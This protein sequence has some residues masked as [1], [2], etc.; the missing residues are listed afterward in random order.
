MIEKKTIVDQIEVTQGGHVQIRFAVQLVEDGKVIDSKWHRTSVVPGGDVDAQIAV[1]NAHLESMGKAR[2]IDTPGV[3]RIKAIARVAH[4]P[5]A[6]A[7]F[8]AVAKG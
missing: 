5:A 7:A 2:V 3:D 6:V 1:V 4:T 8:R